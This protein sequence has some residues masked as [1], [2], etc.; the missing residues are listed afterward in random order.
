MGES[1]TFRFRIEG[2]VS[3]LQGAGDITHG[4][5]V[6]DENENISHPAT[7]RLRDET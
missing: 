3:D 1:L 2:Y 4:K 6:K 7:R 5:V